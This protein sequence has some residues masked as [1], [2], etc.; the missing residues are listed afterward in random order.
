MSRLPLEICMLMLRYVVEDIKSLKKCSLVHRS[1]TAEVQK[2]LFGHYFVRIGVRADTRYFPLDIRGGGKSSPMAFSKAMHN[3][4][5]MATRIRAICLNLSDMERIVT[6]GETNVSIPGAKSKY[7][8]SEQMNNPAW[9]AEALL[10]PVM[11]LPNLQ[12]LNIFEMLHI[13]KI[14]AKPYSFPVMSSISDTLT[15]RLHSVTCVEFSSHVKFVN[16]RD[17]QYFLCSL[18]NLQ[19]LTFSCFSM[20]EQSSSLANSPSNLSLRALSLHTNDKSHDTYALYDA[21]FRWLAGTSTAKSLQCLSAP[22]RMLSSGFGV[23]LGSLTGCVSWEMHDF[24]TGVYGHNLFAPHIVSTHS[25]VTYAGAWTSPG[26]VEFTV[27]LLAKDMDCQTTCDVDSLVLICRK[28]ET[29]ALQRLSI[30]LDFG[31]P[32]IT[33]QELGLRTRPLSGAHFPNLEL[34]SFGY[35]DGVE[36]LY[37]CLSFR[38]AFEDYDARGAI[39]FTQTA[40]EHRECE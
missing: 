40:Y 16:L 25:L 8:L 31:D 18:I 5:R 23:F 32:Y 9:T 38:R 37:N 24:H 26:L 27:N 36:R 33:F 3:N 7:K 28:L 34:L 22:E 14:K 35:E 30:R 1:W 29:P 6:G 12:N 4:P 11:V 13:D 39:Q 10:S 15:T 2:L 20:R 17:L 21:F 19:D